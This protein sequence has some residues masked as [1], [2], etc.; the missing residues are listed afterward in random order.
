MAIL[1]LPGHA[2]VEQRSTNDDADDEQ[3]QVE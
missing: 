1:F 3:V 2:K